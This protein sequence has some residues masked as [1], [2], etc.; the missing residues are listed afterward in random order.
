[1]L[2]NLHILQASGVCREL[3][4]FGFVDGILVHGVIVCPDLLLYS[5]LV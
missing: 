3:A 2:A 4:V 1:M 5:V